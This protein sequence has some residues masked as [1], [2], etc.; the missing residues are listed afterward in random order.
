[1][2]QA[3]SSNGTAGLEKD[4]DNF[5]ITAF[6][7]LIVDNRW[8]IAVVTFVAI[9]VGSIYAFVATPVYQVNLSLQVEDNPGST[10]N[11][12]GE[13]A[14][15]FDVKSAATAEI[16]IL[17]SRSIIG[18]AV[19][20]SQFNID[21]NP[22]RFPI[23]GNW[24]SRGEGEISSP[25]IFG[26]GGYTWG[27]ESVEIKSLKLP[28]D[29]Y[30][31]PFTLTVVTAD[32]FSLSQSDNGILIN[33]RFGQPVKAASQL[34]KI[35]ILVGAVRA[36][37]GAQ[38]D[39]R[40]TAPLETIEDLQRKIVIGEKGKQSGIIGLSLDSP[41]PQKA[42]LFLNEIARVYLQQNV[43]RKSQEA[44]K[45]LEFLDKQ[46][47][48][49]KANL[50]GAEEEYNALRNKRGTV[51][52]GEEAKTV[53]QQSVGYQSRLAELKQKRDELLT[54]FQPA[55]PVVIAVEQQIR[56]I[57]SQL[58]NINGK[59]R[60][61]PATEQEV[62]R[63][64]RNIKVNT[65]L[66]TSLLN[67][68]Q[69]LRLIKASKV[70]NVRLV[71]PAIEPQNPVRPKRTVVILVSTIL[72]LALGVSAALVRKSLFGGVESPHEIEE[73]LGLTVTAAVP[74]SQKQQ[75]AAAQLDSKAK[76]ISVLAHD[77]PA[78][79]A[80]ES[81]RSFRTSLQFTMLNAKNRII[82]ITGPTPGVG[83]S[84]ISANF[85]TV[86]ASTGK[87]VLL[88]DA[89]LR[90]G[91]LQKYFGVAR[92]N[93]LSEVIAGTLSIEKA[94]H[95]NV[96]PNVDFISTGVLPPQPAELLEN[97]EFGKILQ[98]LQTCYDYIVIDTAPILA[99]TDALIVAPHVGAIFNVVR[100]EVSTL[101]EIDEAGRRIRNSG[102]DI[103][104]VIFNDVRY[105]MGKYGYGSRYGKYRYSQYNY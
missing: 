9:L 99:V 40:Y 63:L 82:M 92:S 42:A 4:K 55:N 29:L 32:T 89:D 3:V 95:T 6:L 22:R 20:N 16:E 44:E 105:R 50:E 56:T 60:E 86:L 8:V 97:E 12:F 91:Y 27:A 100:C 76:K 2:N 53:L 51:D 52:L 37:I 28:S 26:V 57:Q 18:K 15:A 96:L 41:D 54:M 59:I 103:A 49:M 78:D 21:A 61:M 46:L 66:Y 30:G 24:A 1:M 62:L 35:E 14:S 73:T 90:K 85:V 88:I 48:V 11:L 64:T 69:Q 47:P 13:L 75:L 79:I 58:D 17:R 25:G 93:G 94:L 5:D 74:H 7:D 72:G 10:A 84:F 70:G 81:L 67:S 71:D 68:A 104:G 38:F 102:H 39:V 31:K 83:K 80:I 19:A 65:D 34:G 98:Y 33:G 87:K 77:D 45:S 43:E 23:I 36:N 101:G